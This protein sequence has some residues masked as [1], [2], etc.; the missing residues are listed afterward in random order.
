M[1]LK[2]NLD[3]PLSDNLEILKISKIISEQLEIDQQIFLINLIQKKWWRKTKNKD[4]IKKLEDLKLHLKNLY[5]TKI[6]LG[7]NFIKN[8][9]EGFIKFNQLLYLLNLNF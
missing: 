4:I 7:S 3:F 8:S 2:K 1:K 5:S 9:Y 6:G